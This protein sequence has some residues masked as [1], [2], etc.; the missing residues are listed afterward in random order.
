MKTR[1]GHIQYPENVRKITHAFQH[2]MEMSKEHVE[3]IAEEAARWDVF[4]KDFLRN[5]FITLK[6]EFGPE[7]QQGFLAYLKKARQ[8][9]AIDT[10]PKLIFFRNST[11]GR[12]K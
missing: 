3:L 11:S 1:I 7:Y 2:S 9:G 5:Y 12:A 10:V 4:S 6:F 8:L